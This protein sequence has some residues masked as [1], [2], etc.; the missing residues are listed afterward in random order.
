MI[1]YVLCSKGGKKIKNKIR[2]LVEKI[3]KIA[4]K[5]EIDMA[6]DLIRNLLTPIIKLAG[7]R[8][9]SGE[10]VF[11][12]NKPTIV[13]VSHEASITGAPLLAYNL[14]K[15]L[16]ED[17]NI[18][19]ILLRE[20]PLSRSFEE[21]SVLV[22]KPVLG[23]IFKSA[24]QHEIKKYCRD[25]RPDYAIVNSIVSSGAIQPLRRIGIPVITLIHEFSAYIRPIN[26]MDTVGLWSNR[27][28]FSSMVTLNDM[29]G[30]YPHLER[31]IC[32]VL[33]QG[34]C[35]N[36]IDLSSQVTTEIDEVTQYINQIEEE[37]VVIIGAGE[38]QP[39]KGVDLF[40]DTAY[41]IK[42]RFPNRKIK[43]AWI[44]SGYDPIND[45]NVSLWIADQIEKYKLTN[46]LKILKPS[47]KYRIL[48]QRA[49]LF[50][51]TSRL[52]PLPNVGIDALLAG[53]PMFCFEKA[54]GLTD[55]LKTN[56]ELRDAL[57]VSYLDT[58]SMSEKVASLLE[59]EKKYYL[60]SDLCTRYAHDWFNMSTYI[61]KLKNLGNIVKEEERIMK[62][63]LRYLMSNEGMAAAKNNGMIEDFSEE[64]LMKYMLSWANN[65]WPIRPFPGFHPG[66]YKEEH[67]QF[68]GDP[69]VH[70]LKENKPRGKWQKELITDRNEVGYQVREINSAIHI[71]VY[72]PE[73]L[74][75]ILHRIKL[76]KANP[77][78]YI[79]YCKVGHREEITEKVLNY[80]LKIKEV[81][82]GPN[83]GRDIGPFL[84]HFSKMFEEKYRIYG[85]IHTKKSINIDAEQG[86]SWRRFLLDSLIG[87]PGVPMMDKIITDLNQDK[88]L[89]L[90]FPNDN[91][92]VGWCNNYNIASEL[93]LQMGINKLPRYIDFPVG[94]MFWAK[95]GALA[96]LYELNLQWEDYPDE[97]LSYDGTMLHALERLLPIITEKE[98][99]KVKTT[100]IDKIAR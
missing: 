31:K 63:D 5:R 27:I 59:D 54:C 20:G 76:N 66:I 56:K 84:C 65:S 49:N 16:K 55:L 11:V 41:K 57:V 40:V 18:I 51:M 26:I 42:M 53:K 94:T 37:E 68:V 35:E 83:R 64:S 79:S 2:I 98:G 77:D 52:D 74:D 99:F 73:L 7:M 28:V 95:K 1:T 61:D 78:I 19:S 29:K 87:A 50:L 43:F 67:G 3:G 85:H 45:F 90:V 44:G 30:R 75:E 4:G 48:M 32:D 69:L 22:L 89:G 36:P 10:K 97:P 62:E 34:Q 71:H 47:K 15:R 92:C 91:I 46:D 23:I 39:R 9:K 86:K 58:N 93:A 100:Y 81:I 82:K 24:L 72:Y 17:N 38:I 14:T 8:A 25:R 96:S 60:I 12:P 21:N 70:Y 33:P 6:K 80:D 13:I 88:N